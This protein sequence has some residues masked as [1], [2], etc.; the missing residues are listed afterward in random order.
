MHPTITQSTHLFTYTMVTKSVL[1]EQSILDMRNSKMN[2]TV[3][4]FQK[5]R[6]LGG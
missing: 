4:T 6:V 2:E 5:L 1:L 3:P